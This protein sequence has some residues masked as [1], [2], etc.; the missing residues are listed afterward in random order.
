MLALTKKGRKIN[1]AFEEIDVRIFFE[2]FPIV[3]KWSNFLSLTKPKHSQKYMMEMVDEGKI[4]RAAGDSRHDLFSKLIDASESDMTGKKLT[5]REVLS[6]IFV[7]L[8]AG[9]QYQYLFFSN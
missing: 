5:D 3:M 9:A 7:F 1:L 6:N 4:A 8:F 2:L